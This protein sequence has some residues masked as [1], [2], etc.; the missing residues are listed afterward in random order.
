MTDLPPFPPSPPVPPPSRGAPTGFQPPLRE[1]D[2]P[3]YVRVAALAEIPKDRGKLV[4][5]GAKR[6][7]LW[8]AGDTI[9]AVK[10]ACP[11]MGDSLARGWLEG[12]VLACPSHHWRFDLATGRSVAPRGCALARYRVKIEGDDVFVS[13]W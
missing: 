10:D 9:Y 2:A 11:H 1:G 8:R 12:S 3:E 13:L 5:V 4:F 6:V 7:A